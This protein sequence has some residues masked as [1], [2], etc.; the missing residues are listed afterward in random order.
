MSQPMFIANRAKLARYIITALALSFALVYL[1]KGMLRVSV[2]QLWY[3][4]RDTQ[5]DGNILVLMSFPI[6]ALIC[7]LLWFFVSLLYKKLNAERTIENEDALAASAVISKRVKVW[8]F[9]VL[10]AGGTSIF[11]VPLVML[12]PTILSED[13][14]KALHENQ[15]KY[16]T[17]VK[18][19]VKVILIIS[20]C[21]SIFAV[22]M[23]RLIND[24]IAYNQ[25]GL[26][27]PVKIQEKP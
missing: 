19:F 24:T 2:N 20:L 4:D 12:L 27:G 11:W 8:C 17:L 21:T 18:A 9:P 5:I 1:S 26:K 22:P 10:I 3:L 25:M 7:V 15:K 23:T 14:L 16:P 6:Y 13:K